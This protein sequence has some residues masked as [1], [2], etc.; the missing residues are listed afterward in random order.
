MSILGVL[1]VSGVC[2]YIILGCNCTRVEMVEGEGVASRAASALVTARLSFP[3]RTRSRTSSARLL[4]N[5]GVRG[6]S[7][8]SSD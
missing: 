3:T 6:G 2:V 7:K 5:I 1:E 4:R 8:R